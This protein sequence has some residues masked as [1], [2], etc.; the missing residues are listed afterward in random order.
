MSNGKKELEFFIKDLSKIFKEE[1]LEKVDIE[2]PR[3]RTEMDKILRNFRKNKGFT[4]IGKFTR[5]YWIQRGWNSEEA[6]M[7][8]KEN[9]VNNIPHGSPMSKEYWMNFKNLKTGNFYTREEA[10][11]KIR[12]QRKSN[13][14]YWIEKGETVNQAKESVSRFQKNNSNSRKAKT[15]SYKDKTWNQYRY[16]MKK[17][18]LLETEAKKKVS[19]L[20]NT[21][22][23]ESLIKK[24]GDIEGIKKYREISEN[25]SSS[26]KIESY[27]KRHGEKEGKKI[28]KE[29]IKKSTLDLPMTSIESIIFFI[30]LYK[31]IREYV[32]RE[33]VFW[34]I[35][36]SKEYFLWD[37]KTSKIFFYD[38]VILSKKII[39]EYHGKRWHPNP[40]WDREKWEKWELFG[41]NSD[42]KRAID[43]YKKSVAEKMGFTIVEVFS[44]QVER[45]DTE[46]FLKKFF[47]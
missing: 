39:I 19:E 42:E 24:H 21:I 11:Y 33:D 5:G 45:F 20:Q 41:M 13:V 32:S 22:S 44:D 8:R 29:K 23:I 2:N 38:F 28:Y 36:G 16:W 34:G 15:N 27:I 37:N 26:Q 17:E 47:T 6:E 4:K 30:P 35:R 40:S 46:D 1:L 9:K 43:L 31:K 14:E 3:N 25:L 12:S 10:E 7:K 18:G